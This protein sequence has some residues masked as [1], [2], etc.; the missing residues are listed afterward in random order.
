M[1]HKAKRFNRQLERF[2]INSTLLNND[3]KVKQ[4]KN[5]MT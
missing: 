2:E 3:T 1:F 4:K 5:I